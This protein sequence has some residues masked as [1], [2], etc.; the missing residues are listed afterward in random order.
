MVQNTNSPSG[1][2]IKTDTRQQLRQLYARSFAEFG[3]RALWNMEQVEEPTPADALAAARQLRIEG[4]L[5]AR[6][7][8][9]Q[10]EA[11]ARAAL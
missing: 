7:L 4:N 11:F 1:G 6:R 2:H 9:E 8:A 5:D 3:T 10:M